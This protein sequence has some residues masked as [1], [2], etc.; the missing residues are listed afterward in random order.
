MIFYDRLLAGAESRDP[1]I[2]LDTA[3]AARE[4]AIAQYAA[5]RF[6]QAVVSLERSVRLIEEDALPKPRA[7][8][9][10]R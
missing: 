1:V 10:P 6:K 7:P 9:I 4:A 3:R 8:M 5:G 2:Q